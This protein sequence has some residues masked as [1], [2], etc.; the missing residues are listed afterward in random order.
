MAVDCH[1]CNDLGF[2]KASDGVHPCPRCNPDSGLE[3]GE[4]QEEQV[5]LKGRCGYAKGGGGRTCPLHKGHKEDHIF[6]CGR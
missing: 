5:K 1:V 3:P 6:E 4:W 2:V